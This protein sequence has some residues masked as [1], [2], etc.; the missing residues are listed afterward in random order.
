MKRIQNEMRQVI[1]DEKES[2]SLLEAAFK[3]IGYEIS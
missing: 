1:K 3:G 2:Q